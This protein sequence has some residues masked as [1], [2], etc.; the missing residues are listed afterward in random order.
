MSWIGGKKSSRDI[1]IPRFP[2]YYEKYIEVFGGGGW[3]L[4]AKPPGNDFEVFNDFNSNI[5][6]LYFC[7]RDKSA[8]LIE[9]LRFVLNSREDLDR[10]KQIGRASCRERVFRAV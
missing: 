6:N 2:L 3:I 4:F 8:E 9:K 7:V 5:S 10:I 1:I